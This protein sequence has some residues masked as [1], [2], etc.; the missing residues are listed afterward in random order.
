MIG[1]VLFGV[2]PTDPPTYS[3]TPIVLALTAFVACYLPARRAM[4]VEASVALREE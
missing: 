2:S 3:V 4:A 1:S